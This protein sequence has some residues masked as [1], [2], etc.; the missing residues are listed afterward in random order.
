VSKQ[1]YNFKVDSKFY[2]QSENCTNGKLFSGIMVWN[3]DH[4][5]V[6]ASARAGLFL[7]CYQFV[8]QES[9]VAAYHQGTGKG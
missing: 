1:G 9:N 6:V 2:V 5:A 8:I 4:R 3:T 7:E